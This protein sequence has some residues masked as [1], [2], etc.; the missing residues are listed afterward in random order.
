[1]HRTL[2]CHH[3]LVQK[4]PWASQHTHH[5]AHHGFRIWHARRYGLRYGE[6]LLSILTDCASRRW[7]LLSVLAGGHGL[8]RRQHL[9]RRRLR[10]EEVL[11]RVRRLLRVP[12]P[13]ERGRFLD[14]EQP[15]GE[16]ETAAN[17]TQHARALALQAAYAR[18]QSATPRDNAPSASQIRN[19]GLLGKTE[20][21]KAVLGQGN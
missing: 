9:G 18:A 6:W 3:C 5:S 7:P 1:M 8:L 10:Q 4:S 15:C 13:Q 20:D 16:K 11:T 2:T 21:T 14:W 19:L 12:T 17:E